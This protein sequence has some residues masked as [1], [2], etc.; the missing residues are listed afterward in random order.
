MDGN[1][2]TINSTGDWRTESAREI[3]Q[4]FLKTLD[5]LSAIN[6]HFRSWKV[7]DHADETRG[8]AVADIRTNSRRSSNV[9]YGRL[10]TVNRSLR[11]DIAFSHPTPTVHHPPPS[12]LLSKREIIRATRATPHSGTSLKFPILR[13]S[14]VPSSNPLWR[15]SFRS[16]ASAER[17]P[18]RTS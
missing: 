16:G 8:I 7:A 4:K 14:P 2:F 6:P 13:S 10:M 3:G 11:E 5:A 9:A 15:L 17:G 1:S 18:F 12:V